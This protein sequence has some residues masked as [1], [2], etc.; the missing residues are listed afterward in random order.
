MRTA[1]SIPDSIFEEADELAAR[2]GLSRSELYAR[3]LE[4]YV[5]DRRCSTVTAALDAVYGREKS[6]GL[7]GA[8]V[9]MQLV[10]LP[11]EEW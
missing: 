5:A 4:R 8:I 3:A 7:D 10:G 1:V 2:L 6:T 11:R 9:A